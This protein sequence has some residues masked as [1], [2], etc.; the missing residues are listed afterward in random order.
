M[1]LDTTPEQFIIPRF[2]VQVSV[3][4]VVFA[5]LRK[6]LPSFFYYNLIKLT[7]KLY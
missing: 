4:N 7:A 2:M 1:E 3:I 6:N 5:T